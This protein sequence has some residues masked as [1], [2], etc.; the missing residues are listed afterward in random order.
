LTY[1][2][3]ADILGGAIVDGARIDLVRKAVLSRFTGD[4]EWLDDRTAIRVASDPANKGFTPA[5][6]K[7]LT[8]EWVE[9]G[10]TIRAKKEDRENW[11]DKRDHW[12]WVVI[13][14]IEGFPTGLFVE[15]ELIDADED[16][17]RGCLV[18][19]HPS[20]RR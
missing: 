9:G 18:N 17:P 8:Q 3:L 2:N 7:K 6:I 19:A 12:Y 14:G 15:M 5:E 16:D 10:G 13:E 4:F 11:R 1:S 20:S